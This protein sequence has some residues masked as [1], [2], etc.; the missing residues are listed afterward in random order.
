MKYVALEFAAY[1]GI[2]MQRWK[3]WVIVDAFF[4]ALS[5]VHGWYWLAVM[6]TI[7]IVIEVICVRRGIP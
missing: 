2:A 1:G 5:L 7:G 6:W 4:I 3:R